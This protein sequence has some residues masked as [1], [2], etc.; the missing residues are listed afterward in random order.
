METVCGPVFCL[1]ESG[2]LPAICIC[3]SP[4]S[5]TLAVL[6]KEILSEKKDKNSMIEAASCMHGSILKRKR[7]MLQP[8]VPADQHFHLCARKIAKT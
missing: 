4:L 7:I 5:S 2:S 8:C 3:L 6:P 1:I